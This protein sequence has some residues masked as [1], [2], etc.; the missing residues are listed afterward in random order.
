MIVRGTGEIL[1]R[2]TAGSDFTAGF[3]LSLSPLN[4]AG[5]EQRPERKGWVRITRGDGEAL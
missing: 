2:R 3:Y 5:G 4:A 1:P